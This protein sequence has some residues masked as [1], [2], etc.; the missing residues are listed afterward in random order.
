MQFEQADPTIEYDVVRRVSTD[1]RWEVGI[2]SVM[3]G[4]RV[5]AGL[6]GS[7]CWSV[8]YCAG[9]HMPSVAVLADVVERILRGF[10]DGAG[11]RE[12]LAALPTYRQRPIFQDPCWHRLLAMAYPARFRAVADSMT[13]EAIMGMLYR[14]RPAAY[15]W[16][17]PEAAAQGGPQSWV[18]AANPA[19]RRSHNYWLDNVPEEPAT[20]QYAELASGPTPQAAYARLI[21]RDLP[22]GPDLTPEWGPD[23]ARLLSVRNAQ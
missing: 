3:F 15:L 10:P 11:T 4:K 7:Q 18:I 17:N 16:L 1:G 22:D 14:Y 21:L 9:P 13:L 20:Y 8:D 5:S 23:V 19:A 12:V 2:R 6:V